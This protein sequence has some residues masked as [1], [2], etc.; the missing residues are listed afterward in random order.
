MNPSAQ[1]QEVIKLEESI[2]SSDQL[3]KDLRE[4]LLNRLQ[5]IK[6]LVLSNGLNLE[7]DKEI[8]YLRFTLSIPFN[9]S[10]QDILDIKRATT[11]LNGH[12][13]GLTQVKERILEYLSMLILNQQK[14]EQ[15]N[16]PALFFV[17]LV[18]SGK[19]SLAYSIA[20]SLGRQIIRIPFGGLGAV[21]LLRGRSRLE[22]EA[23]PGRL[24]KEIA[25]CG[26]NNPV[27]L[28]D[29]IDRVAESFRVDIMGVLVELLDN[30]QNM[31][32][33][34]YY[35]DYPFDLSKVMFIATA[36]NTTNVA[37]AVLDRLEL[38]E[39]PSYSDSDKMMIAR[40]FILPEVLVQAGLSKDTL[41]LDDALWPQL[42]RPLGYDGGIRSLQRTIEGLVR[43]VARQVVGGNP[44]P[45]RLDLTNISQYLPT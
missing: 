3:A 43:R 10:S 5:R 17:G 12:H 18:G 37:T 23:E 27:V 4:S 36:N 11:I 20:E 40:N 21:S 29:E 34:D 16:A 32:F 35:L 15:L 7:V 25:K 42:I 38:I 26:V 39:M 6:K 45:Y 30:T 8:E 13:F 14:G 44:G 41:L 9:H 1:D 22:S 31:S 24:M 28:L 19:T 33:L 2:L